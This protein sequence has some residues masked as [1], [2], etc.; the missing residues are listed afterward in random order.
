MAQNLAAQ[1]NFTTAAQ[2]MH[3]A[4][5]EIEKCSNLPAIS[6]GAAIINA[7]QAVETRLSTKIEASEARLSAQIQ[8]LS[9]RVLV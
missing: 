6:E 7:I 2:S 9:A 3:V 5:D 1:P 8:T 4:A